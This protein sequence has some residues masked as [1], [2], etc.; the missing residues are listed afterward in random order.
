M[1]SNGGSAAALLI[2]LFITAVALIL[3]LVHFFAKFNRY[4]RHIVWKIEHAD[5]DVDRRYW[6][7]ELHCH[8]LRLI[9]FVSEKTV[10]KLHYKMSRKNAREKSESF[11]DGIYH[12][13]A[14]SAV[15]I[16]VCVL[17][18][19]GTS[20][21]WFSS[22]YE[23]SIES[24]RTTQYTAEM[25]VSEENGALLGNGEALLFNAENGKSYQISVT[26]SGT[27]GSS[28]YLIIKF[29]DKK[30]YTKQI[31]AGSTFGFAVEAGTQGELS[32]KYQWG[33]FSKSNDPSV[34][35]IDN[36][37]TLSLQ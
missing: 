4:T 8:Y 14:P 31:K 32:I 28:G 16:V 7:R 19:C 21:A 12:V 20:W 26:A 18:L 15:G 22:S 29:G 37:D 35:K 13:L 25:S 6:L 24:I 5:G 9:P 33:T 30:H 27:E 3:K 1:A 11:S 36:G 10:L 34:V 23:S 2:L 17:C